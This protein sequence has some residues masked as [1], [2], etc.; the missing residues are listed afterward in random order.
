MAVAALAFYYRGYSYSRIAVVLFWFLHLGLVLAAGALLFRFRNRL[1]ARVLPRAVVVIGSEPRVASL[2]PAGTLAQKIPVYAADQIREL[3]ADAGC[4]EILVALSP[5]EL[6]ALGRVLDALRYVS[7]PVRV[8]LNVPGGTS[9]RQAGDLL[10]FNVGANPADRLGYIVA[11]RAL[12]VAIAVTALIGGAPL[13][14]IAATAIRLTA[15]PP[16]LFRQKRIGACGRRFTL[17]K[18]RTFPLQPSEISDRRWSGTMPADAGR[19]GRLLRRTRLDEWPQFWN[20]L[21]GD[22][23]VV[24]PRPER[25]HFAEGFGGALQ[26]YWLRQRLKPG[27]TGLA[28]V[29]GFTGDTQIAGRLECD[30]AYLREWSLVLDFKILLLTPLRVLGWRHRPTLLSETTANISDHA[31][32]V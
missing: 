11:K 29:R 26:S 10:V 27:I 25:P 14:I 22:M 16:V 2:V 7:V 12:D 4:D 23:S 17:Y 5:E 1:A 24:G 8:A 9:F 19:L 30:L 15:G 21:R 28:Q 13:A 20:V 31:R 18:F 3:R 6:D 32:P